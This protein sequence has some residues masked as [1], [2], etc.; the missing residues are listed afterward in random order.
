MSKITIVPNT[1]EENELIAADFYIQ[2][3]HD[4]INAEGFK[5][6]EVNGVITLKKEDSNV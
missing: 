6:V 2:A 3:L 5:V 1:P 4:A